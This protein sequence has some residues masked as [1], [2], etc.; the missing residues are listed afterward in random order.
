MSTPSSLDS[1]F[2]IVDD[3]RPLQVPAPAPSPLSQVESSRVESTST[4]TT[5]TAV[6]KEQKPE[7]PATHPSLDTPNYTPGSSPSYA[8]DWSRTATGG[9]IFMDGRHFVDAY[10]RVCNLRGVNLS[11]S[12]KTPTDHDHEN[13]PGDHLIVTFVG[14]PFPLEEAPEHFARLRRWGLTFIRFLVTWEAVEHAGPGIYDTAYLSYIRSLL[15]L[16]PA[17]GLSAFISMHQDVW[18]RYSGGSGAPAWTLELVGFDL[19]AIEESGGAWLHGQRGGGHVE[20]ERGLWPCGYHKLVASTMSTC[21]WAGD[22]YTPKLR[23]KNKHDQEVSI[24]QFLQ[25]CFLDMWDMVA[26]AVGDLEGVVGFQMINEP[27]PGYV[28][29]SMHG[30]NYNTDLHLS[31]IRE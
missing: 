30:F 15:S 10:G 12:S 21:F 11:G 20:A 18:S 8:H 7:P 29:A 17:Y 4:T 31:H 3:D 26:R 28:N 9:G 14:R 5:T 2:I 1:S 27:H 13:F 6:E 25:N 19:H 16:L 24:Q 22:V 23:V